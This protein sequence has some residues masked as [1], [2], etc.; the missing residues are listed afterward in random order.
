MGQLKARDFA[1]QLN[2]AVSQRQVRAAETLLDRTRTSEKRLLSAAALNTAVA[3]AEHIRHQRTRFA[4]NFRDGFCK[5]S[6][7]P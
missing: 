5:T 7:P 1:A 3:S 2:N 6:I 4:D